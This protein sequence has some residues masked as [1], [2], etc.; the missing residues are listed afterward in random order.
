MTF[1][2]LERFPRQLSDDEFVSLYF[3]DVLA[4]VALPFCVSDSSFGKGD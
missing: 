4:Q 1:A 3:E 2:S